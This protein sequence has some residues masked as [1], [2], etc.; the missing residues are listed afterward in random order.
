MTHAPGKCTHSSHMSILYTWKIFLAYI[1]HHMPGRFFFF[2]W[3]IPNIHNKL[4]LNLAFILNV[5]KSFF[6][7][8][9]VVKKTN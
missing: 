7:F 9:L 6:F 2:S 4:F 5:W 3:R 1:T 8:L